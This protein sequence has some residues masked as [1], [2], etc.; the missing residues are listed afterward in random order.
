[1]SKKPDDLSRRELRTRHS[2]IQPQVDFSDEDWCKIEAAGGRRLSAKQ[3]DDINL[4]SRIFVQGFNADLTPIKAKEI[5]QQI[6]SII[7]HAEALKR[8]LQFDDNP[9]ASVNGWVTLALN[10]ALMGEEFGRLQVPPAWHACVDVIRAANAA[11]PELMVLTVGTLPGPKHALT[12]DQFIHNLER[13][14][15]DAGGKAT[16]GTRRPKDRP[17]QHGSPFADLVHTIYSILANE[18]KLPEKSVGAIGE[19][20]KRALRGS[21]S[22]GVSS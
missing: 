20:V 21:K 7:K 6:E 15:E 9:F 2:T 14:F 4:F 13:V 16:V 18:N 12:M 8:A 10:K 22:T 1:M 17:E 5:E 3:R 11:S 19:A